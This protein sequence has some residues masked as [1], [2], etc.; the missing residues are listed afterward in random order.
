MSKLEMDPLVRIEA[1]IRRGS[2]LPPRPE[3]LERIAARLARRRREVLEERRRFRGVLVLALMGMAASSVAI[4]KLA[5][6]LSAAGVYAGMPA[7][8][9][10][11]I[12]A[13]GALVACGT[14]SFGI[15]PLVRRPRAAAAAREHRCDAPPSLPSLSGR[16]WG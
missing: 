4:P 15:L 6:L 11:M 5:A 10:F 12:V 3:G 16:S 9:V 14:F 13:A 7:F 2:E 1:A 8:S